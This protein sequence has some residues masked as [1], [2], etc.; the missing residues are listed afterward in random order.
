MNMA[1]LYSTV[2]KRLERYLTAS[3]TLSANATTGDKSIT[4]TNA[5][6]FGFQGLID[7]YPNLILMD[8]NTSGEPT[9][10]G[11]RGA[12]IIEALDVDISTGVITLNTPLTRDWTTAN[13]AYAKRAP[14]GVP[15]KD[16][17][18]GDLAVVSKVPTI[19]V[20]P[21]NESIEWSAFHTSKERITIDFMVYVD[22]GDTERATTFLLEITAVVKWIL[23][24]NLHIKPED[25]SSETSVTSYALVEDVDYGSIAKGSEFL[26][27][28]RLTW[29]GDIYVG[30][31]YLYLNPPYEQ[32]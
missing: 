27:S 2:K 28:S 21:T 18:I 32:P 29:V 4:V 31:D 8:N 16:V 17:K 7:Q 9:S 10:T 15:I 24:S 12:E 22:K 30:R 6:D 13:A 14:A 19:C 26:K 11:F 5:N 23:M 3:S 20:V 25:D 1:K